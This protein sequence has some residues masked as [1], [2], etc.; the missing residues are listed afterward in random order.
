M[1]FGQDLL[2]DNKLSC[3]VKLIVSIFLYLDISKIIIDYRVYIDTLI[4]GLLCTCWSIEKLC[5]CQERQ[6]WIIVL[7][8]I[9]L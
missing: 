4:Q 9:V 7:S 1:D 5:E 8:K 3:H 6:P 2:N